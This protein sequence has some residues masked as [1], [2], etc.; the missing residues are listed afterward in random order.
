MNTNNVYNCFEKCQD[1]ISYIH[2]DEQ[3]AFNDKDNNSNMIIMMMASLVEKICVTLLL[4]KY[5]YKERI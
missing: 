1:I 2:P 5:S 3:S 4:H